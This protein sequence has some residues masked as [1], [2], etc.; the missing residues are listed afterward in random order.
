MSMAQGE[1]TFQDLVMRYMPL[2]H[3]VSRRVFRLRGFDG[4][5]LEE[6]VQYGVEGLIQAL[7]KFDV[8]QGARFETYASYRI[9]GAILSGLERSSEV[10]QQIATM[11][12]MEAERLES[13]TDDDKEHDAS[14]PEQAFTRLLNASVGLAI[15]FMLEDTSLYAGEE[16]QHWSDG[17]ANLAFKRLQDRLSDGLDTLNDS[18]RLVIEG[19]YF[20]HMGF[21]EIAGALKLTKGRA[22]QIHRVALAKLRVAIKVQRF[23]D[24]MG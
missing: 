5:E 2:V 21:E 17:Q 9:R 10:N 20:Q 24:L 6:Y 22:S 13:L 14:D 15:A 3:A 12:R 19:H 23:D 8:N 16:G 18:E 4:I 7:N 1:E 11:R